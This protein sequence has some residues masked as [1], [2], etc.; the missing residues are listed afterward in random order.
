MLVKL[1]AKLQDS[2]SQKSMVAAC[3]LLIQTESC[4]VP[5]PNSHG[6]IIWKIF[7][8][9]VQTNQLLKQSSATAPSLTMCVCDQF[10]CSLQHPQN[11]VHFVIHIALLPAESIFVFLGIHIPLFLF[12]LHLGF[13]LLYHLKTQCFTA[14]TLM[15]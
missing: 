9:T 5:L 4:F 2:F 12:R 10:R 14:V 11:S 13:F 15:V 8:D 1:T 3:R 7:V 6:E